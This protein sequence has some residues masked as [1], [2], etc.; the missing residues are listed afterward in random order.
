MEFQEKLLLRFSDLYQL[1]LFLTTPP[2]RSRKSTFM[3]YMC[4]SYFWANRRIR[5]QATAMRAA[6]KK[7]SSLCATDK[8]H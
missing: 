4:E 1:T 3:K 6:P 8:R 2:L 7:H 5:R